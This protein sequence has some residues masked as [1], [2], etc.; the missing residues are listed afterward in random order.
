MKLQTTILL[1][2]FGFFYGCTANNVL[3]K[4]EMIVQS[5]SD[6]IVSD[7]LFENDLTENASYNIRKNGSVAIKFSE[8]VSEKNYTKIVNL[9]RA[10]PSVDGVY[11]E[12]SGQ[13]V[14][15]MR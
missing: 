11:A 10:N 3:T 2:T 8:S 15:G 14:C 13:E 4:E 6:A 7:L 1:L 9:L 12:Q 5:K